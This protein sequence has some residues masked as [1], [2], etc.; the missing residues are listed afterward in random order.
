MHARVYE[1]EAIGS[2]MFTSINV[3]YFAEADVLS[4]G[5]DSNAGENVGH[6]ERPHA[7]PDSA[8]TVVQSFQPA[9]TEKLITELMG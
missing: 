2:Y 1:D 6:A 3:N 7:Y 4:R 5:T 9:L 8:G